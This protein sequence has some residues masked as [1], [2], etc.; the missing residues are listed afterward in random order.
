MP[1][2]TIG[3]K[4]FGLTGLCLRGWASRSVDNRG[5]TVLFYNHFVSSQSVN[6]ESNDGQAKPVVPHSKYWNHCSH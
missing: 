3:G 4:D 1:L 6:L 5:V 2:P